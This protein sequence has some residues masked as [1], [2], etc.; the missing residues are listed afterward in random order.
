M[1]K[2]TLIALFFAAAFISSCKEEEPTVEAQLIG[3][4]NL[5]EYY[6]DGELDVELLDLMTMNYEFLAGGTGKKTIN[7]LFVQPCKWS[8]DDTNKKLTLMIEDL[9]IEGGTVLG[10]TIVADIT[11]LDETNLW[12]SHDEDGLAI[13]ERYLKS[14]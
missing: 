13:G 6:V 14:N 12:L 2:L 7:D 3:V 10:D 8:Y 9:A 4:W 5:N 11:K 1:N